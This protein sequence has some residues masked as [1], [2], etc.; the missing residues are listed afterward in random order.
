M[1]QHLQKRD[2][3]RAGAAGP[4]KEARKHKAGDLASKL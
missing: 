4:D 3:D 1:E 2:A